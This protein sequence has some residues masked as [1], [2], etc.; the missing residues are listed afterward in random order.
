MKTEVKLQPP[1]LSIYCRMVVWWYTA[2]LFLQYKLKL[3][4]VL[5]DLCLSAFQRSVTIAVSIHWDLGWSE[6]QI[7]E[8]PNIARSN[9]LAPANWCK[10]RTAWFNWWKLLLFVGWSGIYRLKTATFNSHGLMVWCQKESLS[11]KKKKKTVLMYL[12]LDNNLFRMKKK[13]HN[14][15]L[16][17]TWFDIV[18]GRN[19]A[20]VGN[21]WRYMKKPQ[22]VLSAKSIIWDCWKLS[23]LTPLCINITASFNVITASFIQ[24]ENPHKYSK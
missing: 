18:D 6:L 24:L 7:Q 20:P 12:I 16:C 2:L 14:F 4:V 5:Y 23:D 19:L 13:I 9:L 11:E 1:R 17:I 3:T 8:S 21:I 15:Q 10:P 22:A